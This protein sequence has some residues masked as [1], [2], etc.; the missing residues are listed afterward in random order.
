MHINLRLIPTYYINLDSQPERG[1]ST[2]ST[3]SS[4][5]FSNINRIA[6]VCDADPKVG[7]ALSHKKIM[8][9]RITPVPITILE[10]DIVYTGAPLEYDIPDDADAL[11]LGCSQWGRLLNFSGPFLQY[12]NISNDVVRIY[13]MLSTHAMVFFNEGYRQHLGRIAQHSAEEHQYHL[14][15]GY[16]ETQRYYKVYALNRPVFKQSGYNEPVTSKP[17]TE[18]GMDY[19]TS[20]RYFSEVM[21]DLTKINGVPDLKGSPSYYDP[22][23]WGPHTWLP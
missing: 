8:L 4:L 6:G 2:Q 14:D 11:Y 1:E 16:A 3:L 21:W 10:D 15:I 23:W 5:G 22:R 19:E 13:N 7:C 17:I 12:K 18:M 9:N 20:K